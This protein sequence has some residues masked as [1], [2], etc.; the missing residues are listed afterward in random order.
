MSPAATLNN[1]AL[2]VWRCTRTDDFGAAIGDAVGAVWTLTATAQ[3]SVGCGAF[4]ATRFRRSD[5]TCGR[6]GVALSLAGRAE[7]TL[8]SLVERTAHAGDAHCGRRKR[9]SGVRAT[10][11]ARTDALHFLRTARQR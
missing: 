5:A 1:L 8:E 10:A 2:V 4:K 7:V 9:L 3:P 6:V 11:C